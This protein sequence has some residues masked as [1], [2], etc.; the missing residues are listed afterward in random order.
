MKPAFDELKDQFQKSGQSNYF[1]GDY[2]LALQ[3]FESILA[4][5]K[6]EVYDNLIDTMMI[7]FSGI[8]ARELGRVNEDDEMYRHAI[9][10]YKKLTEL[11]YGG[12][13]MFIQMTRDY[14]IIGDTLGAINNLKRGLKLYPDSSLLV[15]LTAQAYYLV[16]DNEGG[17]DFV[18]TRIEETPDCAT[19]FYWKGLLLTNEDDLSEDTIQLALELYEQSLAIDPTQAAVSYQAGYVY[20]AV[21]ANFYELE[22]YEDDPDYRKE[23]T[24]KGSANYE[25]SAVMLE[26][27]YEIAGDD[28]TLRSESLDF[29]KRIYYKLYGN[30][31]SRY[32]DVM[33]RIKAL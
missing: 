33:E 21:G 20:Y 28:F 26:K 27:T 5:N 7:N 3:D 22:G 32:L 9:S 31:D 11:S 1:L 24:E 2:A 15:T 12:T 29:L 16:G 25:K 30:E 17:M 8:V 14:Y 18:D 6:F 13:D 23:L 19:A 4:V 10:Y